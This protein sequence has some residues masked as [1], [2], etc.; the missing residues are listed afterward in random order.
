MCFI[1]QIALNKLWPGMNYTRSTMIFRRR[2][3][4]CFCFFIKSFPFKLGQENLWPQMLLNSV[5]QRWFN[6]RDVVLV[7]QVHVWHRKYNDDFSKEETEVSIQQ[8]LAMMK[9]SGAWGPRDLAVSQPPST[10]FHVSYSP[11]TLHILT[12]SASTSIHEKQ[13]W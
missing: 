1:K 3:I 13:C 8:E 6:C 11:S 5:F 7:L 10:F 9:W 4:Y 12:L 2:K